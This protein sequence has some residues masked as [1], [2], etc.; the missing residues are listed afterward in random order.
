MLGAVMANSEEHSDH[1]VYSGNLREYS[2]EGAYKFSYKVFLYSMRPVY[3]AENRTHWELQTF[4]Q[5]C[6]KMPYGSDSFCFLCLIDL[7]LP[8]A[9]V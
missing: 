5:G 6:W 1:V 8:S 7:Q 2:R 4:F 9:S 3:S